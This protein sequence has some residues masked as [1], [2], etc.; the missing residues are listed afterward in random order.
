MATRLQNTRDP[1]ALSLFVYPGLGQMF[2][3]RW[4]TGMV[5]ILLFTACSIWLVAELWPLVEFIY[6]RLP[7]FERS[8]PDM[9]PDFA[10]IA[11]PLISCFLILSLNIIDVWRAAQCIR[12]TTPPPVPEG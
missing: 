6:F 11:Q 10:G 2:Q 5:F 7:D 8:L 4:K 1:V 3:R 12:R 9:P